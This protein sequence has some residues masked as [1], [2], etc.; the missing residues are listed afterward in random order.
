MSELKN[1]PFCGLQAKIDTALTLKEKGSP[2]FLPY[3]KC[4]N[5]NASTSRGKNITDAVS[6]WN[7]RAEKPCICDKLP[8]NYSVVRELNKCQ[9]AFNG[10]HE[11]YKKLLNLCKDILRPLEHSLDIQSGSAIHIVLR[12]L[13]KEI[14]ENES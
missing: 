13:F 12:E 3:V 1:C 10:Q 8:L 5:C 7:I 4:S 2:H 9:Q 6:K 14:G 11:K